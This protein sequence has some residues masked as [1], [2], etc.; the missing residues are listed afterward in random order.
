[1]AETARRKTI[2]L[3]FEL[4]GEVESIT[5][6]EVIIV[7]RKRHR[8]K[9]SDVTIVRYRHLL[10]PSKSIAVLVLDDGTVRIRELRHRN[11]VSAEKLEKA[12]GG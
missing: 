7:S 1:M 2:T 12:T 10:Q 4:L 9:L 6:N 5:D 3:W 11:G 8:V